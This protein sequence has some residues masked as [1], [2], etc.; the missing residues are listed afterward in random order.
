[1][2]A[3]RTLPTRGR[4]V[5]T[6]GGTGGHVFP[7][8]ALAAELIRRGWTVDFATDARGVA[9]VRMP[10]GVDVH[11]LPAGGVSGMGMGRRLKGAVELLRG[12]ARARGLMRRL[13]PAAV[14][15]FGSYAALPATLAALLAGLPVGLH[16][17][18][19]V[20]GRANRLLGRKARLLALSVADTRAVPDAARPRVRVTGNPVRAEVAA[21]ADMPYAAPAAGEDF[22]LFSTGGSQG[23]R[24]LGTTLPRAAALLPAALKARTRLVIQVRPEDMA[25]A[26]A[27]LAGQGFAAVELA[28]FFADMPARLA[29]AHLVVARS[30]A[31]TV[32]ELAAAGRPS[33]LVPLPGAIDDHQTANA[34][35]LVDAGA[36][37][38][39]AQPAATP[40]ALARAIADLA[41]DPAR[42]ARMAEAA[43][44]V[45]RADAAS[46]LADLVEALAEGRALPADTEGGLRAAATNQTP[47]GGALP[48]GGREETA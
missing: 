24:F 22:V 33:L 38:A 9:H 6:T 25:G 19:A 37:I 26:E 12:V 47:T 17:Q 8:R 41:E 34:R 36:A 27:A 45:G 44:G 23:A 5:V 18:N 31:S 46:R 39:M 2:T 29:A 1:M 10:E 14:I 43:L 35:A 30:G 40:E 4:I 7:A 21:V 28:P 16:E 11:A 48:F 13:A 32:A 42:L 20:L 15:G 3:L